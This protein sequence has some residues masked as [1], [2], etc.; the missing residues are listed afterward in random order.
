MLLA[1]AMLWA[2][3]AGVLHRMEHAGGAPGAHAAT[4]AGVLAAQASGHAAGLAV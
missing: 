4:A 1:L 2:Q 3:V